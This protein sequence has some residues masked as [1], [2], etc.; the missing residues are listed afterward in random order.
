MVRAFLG[1]AAGTMKKDGGCMEIVALPAVFI[2][3]EGE[4]VGHGS[5]IV[6]RIPR[7]SALGLSFPIVI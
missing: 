5:P 7:T 4:R 2:L 6:H 3:G 1:D